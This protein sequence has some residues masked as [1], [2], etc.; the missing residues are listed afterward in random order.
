MPGDVPTV[1]NFM[2][3]NVFFFN[4]RW[5]IFGQKKLRPVSCKKCCFVAGLK[6]ISNFK[7]PEMGLFAGEELFWGKVLLIT[8]IV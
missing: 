4:L 2:K 6:F 7:A 3:I 8:S 1:V 5:Y